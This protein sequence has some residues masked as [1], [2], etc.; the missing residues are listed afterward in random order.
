MPDFA[1]TTA[2]LLGF[3][4]CALA[5][6]VLATAQR[7]PRATERVARDSRRGARAMMDE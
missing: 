7:R 6:R 3:L 4:A 2:V 1:V 5:L